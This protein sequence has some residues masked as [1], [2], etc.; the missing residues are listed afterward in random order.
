MDGREKKNPMVWNRR[1]FLFCI[2]VLWT[3]A[4]FQGNAVFQEWREEIKLV[5][6]F[7]LSGACDIERQIQEVKTLGGESMRG[8]LLKGNVQG[9]MSM[10]EKGKASDRLFRS[11]DATVV[12]AVRKAELY[13]VYGSSNGLKCSLCYGE[14][15]I[16]LNLAFA[17]DELEDK[18]VMYLAVPFIQIDY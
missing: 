15:E 17:Y 14:K 5:E 8:M 3:A 13:T 18:T 16:N 12:E 1:E 9:S 2:V 4:I 11:L 6:A 10:D 7:R